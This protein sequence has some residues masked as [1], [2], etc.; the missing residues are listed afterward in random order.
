MDFK[1]FVIHFTILK[2]NGDM[3][4][5]Y[6]D[7]RKILFLNLNYLFLLFSE[8]LSGIK[9]KNSENSSQSEKSQ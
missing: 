9:R 8:L 4:N 1:K 2:M 5:L 6:E 3:K 7:I